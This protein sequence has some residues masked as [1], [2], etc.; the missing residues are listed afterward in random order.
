MDVLKDWMDNAAGECS[1]AIPSLFATNTGTSYI[2]LIRYMYDTARELLDRFDWANC[3]LDGTI[4]GDGST[5]Y[6]LASDFKRLTRR[7][8]ESDPAVWSDDMRRAFRAV[9]SNGQWTVLQSMGATP[10]YGY[11]IVGSTIEFTQAI[12]SG[13]TVT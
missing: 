3:T 4:T 7:D 10:S 1:L 2:Q 8:E 5:S 9:T 11:R 13:E 12:A 6:S